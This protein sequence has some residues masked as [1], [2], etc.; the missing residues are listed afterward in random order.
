MVFEY[1]GVLVT[2]VGNV[3]PEVL[4]AQLRANGFKWCACKIHDGSRI[5]NQ[6]QFGNV[7]WHSRMKNMGISCGAWG[8]VRTDPT[9]EAS[10]VT[11]LV[12]KYNFDFYIADAEYEYEYTND[13]RQDA[14][15]FQRSQ[16]FLSSLDMAG[17]PL[18]MTTFGILADH[19]IWYK[20]WYDAGAHVLPEAYPSMTRQTVAMALAGRVLKNPQHDG[21]KEW[22]RDRVHPMISTEEGNY[23]RVSAADYV[24]ML[25]T[26]KVWDYSIFTAEQVR[27]DE[28]AVYGD[29][30]KEPHAMPTPA[31]SPAET[32][33]DDMIG[34]AKG[35]E[36]AWDD[37]RQMHSNTRITIA[38]R[39]LE[40]DDSKLSPAMRRG[41]DNYLTKI[42]L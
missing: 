14:A 12:R 30:N 6:E 5:D 3:S 41:L 38:R 40:A 4:G 21:F 24:V 11:N 18:G 37:R 31:K 32:A 22:P 8:P 39:I 28:W 2:V 23:G 29:Y 26:A 19:D 27:P 9:F 36:K 25:R 13:G 1:P 34:I 20:P 16:T 15:R 35:I 10:I 17:K 7:N 42:G 33:R